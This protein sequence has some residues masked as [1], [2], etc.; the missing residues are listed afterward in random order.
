M[1]SSSRERYLRTL[2]RYQ[3]QHGREKASAIQERFWKDRERVVSESAEEIDWFP[4][5]KK[6]QILESLLEKTYRDLIREMEHE[7]LP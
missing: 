4:S 6:N 7:G 3:E 5:W 2:M 1:E